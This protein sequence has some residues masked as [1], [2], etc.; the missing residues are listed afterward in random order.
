MAP[1]IATGAIRPRT[2]V[3]VGGIPNVVTRFRLGRIASASPQGF[4][5]ETAAPT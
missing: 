1:S 2:A 3:P 4:A 5:A